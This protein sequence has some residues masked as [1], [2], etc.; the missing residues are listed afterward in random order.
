MRVPAIV[1]WQMGMISCS[2]DSKTLFCISISVWNFSLFFAFSGFFFFSFL[3]DLPVEVL[4]ATD[5]DDSIGISQARED[6]DTVFVRS[7]LVRLRL[8]LAYSF[9]FSN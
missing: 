2:S 9:E 6:A 3:L 5:S 1:A 8:G 7:V 4:R